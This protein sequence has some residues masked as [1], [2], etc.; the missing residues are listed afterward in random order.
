MLKLY[1]AT[2]KPPIKIGHAEIAFM[3]QRIN[4][5]PNSSVTS[6][7][8]SFNDYDLTQFGG[9]VQGSDITDAVELTDKGSTWKTRALY[10]D[11]E[12][13]RQTKLSLR[14]YGMGYSDRKIVDIVVDSSFF[15]SKRSDYSD[16]LFRTCVHDGGTPQFM[17]FYSSPN[18]LGNN[19]AELVYFIQQMIEVEK[20]IADENYG[21]VS[22]MHWSPMLNPFFGATGNGAL[23]VDIIQIY[24]ARPTELCFY[25]SA[26]TFYT[27]LTGQPLVWVKSMSI[28]N[29]TITFRPTVYYDPRKFKNPLIYERKNSDGGNYAFEYNDTVELDEHTNELESTTWQGQNVTESAKWAPKF[30]QIPSVFFYTTPSIMTT[31]LQMDSTYQNGWCGWKN[32]AT[33]R[34]RSSWN[35]NFAI[36]QLTDTNYLNNRAKQLGT[37]ALRFEDSQGQ[38][39]MIAIEF[40]TQEKENAYKNYY[41]AATLQLEDLSGDKA[42]ELFYNSETDER[43]TPSA[44]VDDTVP[45]IGESDF[46]G[47]S[48]EDNIGGDGTWSDKD[49]NTATDFDNP[50]LSEDPNSPLPSGVFGGLNGNVYYVLMNSAQFADLAD[51]VYVDNENAFLRFLHETRGQAQ[52][53]DGVFATYISMIDIPARHSATLQAIAGYQLPQAI[54]CQTVEQYHRFNLGSV[55]IKKVF[56]NYLDYQTQISLHL[57]FATDIN[58]PVDIVMGKKLQVGLTLDVCNFTALYTIQCENHLI[59]EVP[60]NPFIQ[61]PLATS[62]YKSGLSTMMGLASDSMNAMDY[63][64]GKEAKPATRSMIGEVEDSMGNVISREYATSA[65]TEATQAGL[66]VAGGVA[67]AVAIAAKGATMLTEYDQ[68]RSSTLISGGGGPGMFGIMGNHHAVLK[69]S[70]PYV[71][72]DDDYYHFNGAPSDIITTLSK[73]KGYTEVGKFIPTESITSEELCELQ[74]ILANG[75]YL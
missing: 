4:A 44:K 72:I 11:Q 12:C 43:E 62:D 69:I 66:G 49:D 26:A 24:Y 70:R 75:V 35:Y 53:N 61:V 40:T 21:A 36:A 18:D 42:L 3:Q 39:P 23:G 25:N 51:T 45:D 6:D 15:L 54:G 41:T 50:D 31:M 37:D 22:N 56:G 13:T 58:I 64:Q 63:T 20:Q 17:S 9:T 48:D 29:N 7:Y 34:E 73:C 60:C 19:D 30:S 65:A 10:L 1:Y 28:F 38:M 67:G 74:E 27:L 55:E 52:I 46:G 57:P 16:I 71:R 5:V 8:E 68:S 2:D 47:K 59:A 33:K 32:V 14:Y